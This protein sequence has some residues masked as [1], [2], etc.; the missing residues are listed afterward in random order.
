[1]ANDL[2][3]ILQ[4][5]AQM[6]DRMSQ[7][8]AQ[9][10]LDALRQMQIGLQERKITMMEEAADLREEQF[11]TQK[12]YNQLANLE[13]LT[14]TQG[15]EVAN[16]FLLLTRF[17]EFY[18]P[19][20]ENWAKDFRQ[21]LKG[22]YK[23][24]KIL[25]KKEVGFGFSDRNASLILNT[26]VQASASKNPNGILHLINKADIAHR[27]INEGRVPSAQD[28]NLLNG[29]TNMGLFRK[30]KDSYTPSKD[31]GSMM[32]SADNVLTNLSNLSQE[33]SEITTEKIPKIEKDFQFLQHS[34][35]PS[36]TST[37]AELTDEQR[38]WQEMID[39]FRRSK[40]SD[41]KTPIQQANENIISLS[42]QIE[43]KEDQI[44]VDKSMLQN[45]KIAQ[46]QGLTVDA[47]QMSNLSESIANNTAAKDSI[48]LI[49]RETERDKE[50][51]QKKQSLIDIGV[52][53][54]EENVK[55]REIIK[56]Q[57]LDQAAEE[58][59]IFRERYRAQ[60]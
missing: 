14:K 9:R 13:K 54:T 12:F 53:P 58:L 20:D 50:L 42:N 37:E 41:F 46:N 60:Q 22:E 47:V 55:R 32:M 26:V 43:S 35:L 18:N 1:M 56:Q 17:N 48:F 44:A 16:R 51:T 25:R 27:M 52:E 40:E 59:A 33:I 23:T 34:A 38:K 36:I 5:T 6:I 2:S 15:S 7:R 19:E 30:G 3:V 29:L 11:Q 8:K 39:D 31:M 45:M 24:G 49:K 28:Q 10:N 57:Q 4:S 21:I